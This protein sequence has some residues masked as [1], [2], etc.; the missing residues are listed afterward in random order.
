MLSGLLAAPGTIT[1]TTPEYSPCCSSTPLAET[2]TLLAVADAVSHAVP[3]NMVATAPI[4]VPEGT[5]A[6]W[7]V[8]VGGCPPPRVWPNV[9]LLGV[10]P[11]VEDA[12]T[13]VT[14]I[15][16]AGTFATEVETVI[17]PVYVPIARFA[18]LSV[19]CRLLGVLPLLGVT[20]SQ[21]NPMGVVAAVAVN[22]NMVLGL[23]L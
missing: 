21:V 2:E 15:V 13:R 22:G 7:T 4:V 5:P 20:A 17:E 10:A 16:C 6:I 12:I 1:V 3:F 23:V 18:G 11:T 9:R 8:W 14:G 19:I